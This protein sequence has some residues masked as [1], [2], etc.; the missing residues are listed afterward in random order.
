MQACSS[1]C[2]LQTQHV[3]ALRCEVE[4]IADALR[5]RAVAVAHRSASVRDEAGLGNPDTAKFCRRRNTQGTAAVRIRAAQAR[6]AALHRTLETTCMANN[7]YNYLREH[8]FDDRVGRD[9]AVTILIHR[10]L[11]FLSPCAVMRLVQVGSNKKR[12][13]KQTDHCAMTS[14]ESLPAHPDR[15]CSSSNM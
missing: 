15:N 11:H 9:F 8:V 1:A 2:G 10:W 3:V 7:Y 14:R 5:T 4:S 12:R 13:G 6:D